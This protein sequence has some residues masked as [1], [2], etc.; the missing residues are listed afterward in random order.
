MQNTVVP[1][2]IAGTQKSWMTEDLS[3]LDAGNAYQHDV[4]G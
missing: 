1:V 3:D 2:G 4:L